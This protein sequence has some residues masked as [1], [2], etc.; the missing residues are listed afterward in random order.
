MSFKDA[1]KS[2]LEHEGGYSNHPDDK[3]G[4]TNYG[5]TQG[6][7]IRHGFGDVK[8]LSVSDAEFIYKT[9]YWDALCCGE[10]YDTALAEIVFDQAVNVGVSAAIKRLQSAYNSGLPE[11]PL[12]RDGVMGPKTLRAINR[13]PTKQLIIQFVALTYLY[14]ANIVVRKPSQAAFLMGWLKRANTYLERLGW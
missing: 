1:V 10:F 6:V 12:I 2:T 9:D 5:I 3:G 13:D 7:A 11:T 8:Y 14:Y 4:P